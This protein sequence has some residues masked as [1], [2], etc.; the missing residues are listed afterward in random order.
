MKFHDTFNKHEQ[1]V[2]QWQYDALGGFAK[3][4]MKTIAKADH[5]NSAKLKRVYPDMVT[6]YELYAEMPGWWEPVRQRFVTFRRLQMLKAGLRIKCIEMG[7][8]DF[9]HADP[10]PIKNSENG[11]VT[12]W[13]QID[14]THLQIQVEWDNG[15]K[16]SLIVP[17][18]M[19]EVMGDQTP[20][21]QKQTN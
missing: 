7:K 8:D 6:A 3:L 5:K 20:Y 12:G 16:L 21:E 10:D 11:T 1:I 17:P 4:L 15:R 19:Y 18:D 14:P 9:G 13:M 2:I